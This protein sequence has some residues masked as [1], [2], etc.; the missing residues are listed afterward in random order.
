[1]ATGAYSSENDVVRQAVLEMLERDG[2]LA[3]QAGEIRARIDEG[4][5]SAERD[6][7]MDEDQVRRE[8]QER[9]AKARAQ[10]L[11]S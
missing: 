4:W 9:K 11:A 8:M 6:E 10:P 7:L 1:M 5:E 2:F 3:Q